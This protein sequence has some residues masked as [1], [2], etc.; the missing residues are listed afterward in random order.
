MIPSNFPTHRLISLVLA[1]ALC[2]PGDLRAD[3]FSTPEFPPASAAWLAPALRL[4]ATDLDANT[5]DPPPARGWAPGNEGAITALAVDT[6]KRSEVVAFFHCIYTPSEDFES[7]HGWTGSLSSCVAGTVSQELHDDVL[8]R[9]NYYRAMAGLNADISLDAVKNADCQEA[10]LMMARNG[11][12][13]HYPP[14]NW[15]CYTANGY[16]A[17]GASN[18]S[19][20]F[21]F[22]NYG[23]GSID[24]Q[25]GDA[26][27]NN[28]PV[29]HRRW[30]LYSRA[31]EMG[32][33]SI[34]LTPANN[35]ASC[36]VWVIGS[37]NAALPAGLEK[38]AWPP[39]GHVPHQAVWPR[40]SFGLPNGSAR[41]S[42]ATVTM[43][44]EGASI[45]LTIIHRG[46]S[47]IGDPTIVWEPSG[48][49]YPD[50]PAS[51]P[52]ADTTFTVTVAG[53]T[54]TA[55]TSYSYD[56]TVINPAAP[57]D[58]TITGPANPPTNTASTYTFNPLE[59]AE[60]YETRISE[61]VAA[62]WIEGAEAGTLDAIVDQ[63]TA[64]LALQSGTTKRTGSYA[65]HLAFDVVTDQGFEVE[66]PIIP[67]A[68]SRLTFYNLRRWATTTSVLYAEVSADGGAT[69]DEIWSRAGNGSGSSANWD[70]SYQSVSEP[71]SA[72][73]GE[74]LKLRFV[75][76]HLGGSYFPGAGSG[77]GFYLDDITVT[78]SRV[79]SNEAV[80]T[81][82]GGSSSFTFLPGAA[83][84]DYYLQFRPIFDCFEFGFG[85]ALAVTSI[86]G[87][88]PALELVRV[89]RS[90]S[91][92][93]LQ[94]RVGPG[95][96]FSLTLRRSGDLSS[97][98]ND[99]SAT[100]T[101]HGGGSYTF[102]TTPP[103][104]ES[105]AFYTVLIE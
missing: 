60:S 90:G 84:Q 77:N 36:S 28:S 83:N 2:A 14:S 53:I 72:Y 43:S 75:Y 30:L 104:G 50:Y 81:L 64:G 51:V 102:R 1:A 34:P 74:V 92:L 39:E 44:K 73:A 47:S 6:S 78:D 67:T 35:T 59:A 16:T 24:G 38:I 20:G 80:G 88:T 18:L 46:T 13:S 69:W 26:G 42:S 25:M 7:H 100:L 10:A 23:V 71:L 22:A 105:R 54:G 32:H 97:W 66:R 3:E 89:T 5:L 85:E 55:Q 49:D 65:F 96:F 21:N 29:G 79:L 94:I 103:G 19:I 98:S 56:V 27:S 17:A 4:S 11:A 63:T 58:L 57:G 41:F 15:A 101:D 61:V 40:W 87:P 37:F 99:P 62:N 31:Q 76:H 68:A 91:Y 45:P 52:A 33:G 9:I 8:R 86:Q 93:D 48:P 82:P 70:S 12:L 95:S